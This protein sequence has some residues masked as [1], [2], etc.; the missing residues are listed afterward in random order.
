MLQFLTDSSC[1]FSTCGQTLSNK[2]FLLDVDQLTSKSFFFSLQVSRKPSRPR[3]KSIYYHN[4]GTIPNISTVYSEIR[5]SFPG[6][7]EFWAPMSALLG[8]AGCIGTRSP[9]RRTQ[10]YGRA[11]AWQ[12]TICDRKKIW[13]IYNR[14]KMDKQI[15]HYL[16][17]QGHAGFEKYT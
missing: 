14:Q 5:S 15:V 11:L 4:A 9:R 7:G 8:S 12:R 16:A 2:H 17:R 3:S 1:F 6:I 13:D 10:S